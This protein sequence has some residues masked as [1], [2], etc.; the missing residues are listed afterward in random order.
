METALPPS[1]KCAHGSLCARHPSSACPVTPPPTATQRRC[2]DNPPTS[3]PRQPGPLFSLLWEPSGYRRDEQGRGPRAV[4][5][6]S[7]ALR[8]PDAAAVP[9]GRRDPVALVPGLPRRAAVPVS[10][11][12]RGTGVRGP[13]GRPVL[14]LLLLLLSLPADAWYKHVASP[15]YH[16]VGRAAG[17][18]MG[19]RRSPYM[20]RRA[21]RLAAG[22]VASDT[23]GLGSSPQE[24]SAR[25][26]LR[27]A[28]VPRGALLL[29][30]GVRELLETGRHSRA[31][32]RVSA[33][34]SWRHPER[35]SELEPGLFR[36][37]GQSLW[38]V[39]CSATV[40]PENRVRRT[41]P[42]QGYPE[43]SPCWQC[44]F[45]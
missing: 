40:C 22:P 29:P 28:P 42:L 33:P 14:A 18:L 44:P 13:A 12:A 9:A 35:A 6:G 17:L 26:T 43:R 19:L 25:D 15:R 27:P 36:G 3:L 2:S 24:P 8:L 30:S 37:A 20:H 21:L 38:R 7:P 10:I 16:T 1:H 11:L 31:G 45:S 39:S 32:L 4:I 5:V 23:Q 41:P 34:W